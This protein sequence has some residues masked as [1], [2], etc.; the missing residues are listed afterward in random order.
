MTSY[1]LSLK[2]SN[3]FTYLFNFLWGGSHG[4]QGEQKGIIHRKRLYTLFLAIANGV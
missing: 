4:F 2:G 3:D 1:H